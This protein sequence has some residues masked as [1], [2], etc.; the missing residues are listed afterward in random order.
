MILLRKPNAN[1]NKKYNRQ[2]N[3]SNDDHF[4]EMSFH[5]LE[6]FY[7]TKRFHGNIVNDGTKINYKQFDKVTLYCLFN[8][9]PYNVLFIFA[10]TEIVVDCLQWSP[11]KFEMK[12]VF[13]W[14]LM[15]TNAVKLHFDETMT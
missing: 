5:I 4:I 6:S 7:K 10:W 12:S 8:S 11:W 2:Y 9:L 15:M 3:I 14:W 13:W 1:I